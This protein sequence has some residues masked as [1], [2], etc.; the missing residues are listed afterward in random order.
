MTI[1]SSISALSLDLHFVHTNLKPA[2]R[3]WT[4]SLAITH[5]PIAAPVYKANILPLY[6]QRQ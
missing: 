5:T 2:S 6:S 1:S 4:N 3:V